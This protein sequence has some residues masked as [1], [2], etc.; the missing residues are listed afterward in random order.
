MPLVFVKKLAIATKKQNIKLYV[1]P[2]PLAPHSDISELRKIKNVYVG[3]GNKIEDGKEVFN[4]NHMLH[5]YLIIKKNK[6]QDENQNK[7][8]LS[9]QIYFFGG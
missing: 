9:S 5:K 3:I 7:S 8:P 6:N 2:Y 4:L 1:R